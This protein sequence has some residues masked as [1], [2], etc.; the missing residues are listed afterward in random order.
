MN[1]RMYRTIGAVAV[2]ALLVQGCGAPYDDRPD[3]RPVPKQAP[4]QTPMQAPAQAPVQTSPAPV[5]PS[6]KPSAIPEPSPLAKE[7]ASGVSAAGTPA[8]GAPAAGASVPIAQAPVAST[9]VMKLDDCIRTAL[10]TSRWI[11]SA[12]RRIII[13]EDVKWETIAPALPSLNAKGQY[14]MRNSQPGVITPSGPFPF[15][16]KNVGTA[17]LTLLVPIYS[18]GR[19][20]NAFDNS[21]RNVEATR[22]NS[23]RSRQEV[24]YAVSLSY[25]RVLEAKKTQ[26]VVEESIELVQRQ[27]EIAREFLAQGIVARSDVLTSEVQL[28][29]RQQELIQAR[30]NVQLAVAVLNRIMG[31]DVNRDTQIEDAL[32]TEPWKGDYT[33]VLGAA[34]D[35]RPDLQALKK[36]VEA[37]QSTYKATR[38]ELFPILYLQGMANYT[39]DKTQIHQEWLTGSGVVQWPLFEGGVTYTRLDRRQ[40]EIAEALGAH[41]DLVD[42]ILLDV[43]KSYFNMREASERIPVARKAVELAEENL[44]VIRDQYSQGI[45]STT[46]VLLEEDRLSHSRLSYYRALYDY[47]NAFAS[48]TNATGGPL[49]AFSTAAPATPAPDQAANQEH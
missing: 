39:S 22:L 19:A 6:A 46:D 31:M 41:D 25:F 15:G 16:R 42:D 48:L 23:E 9:P 20:S 1:S 36:K 37:A 33:T 40:Q 13:A 28:A 10:A 18:F 29:G 3:Y 24:T 14:D 47:H 34:I 30:N 27:L 43:K 11:A 44:R 12:D 17:N 32:E 4:S 49:D 45:V 5:P 35:R 26:K 8:A 38:A 2:S 21:S 7:T